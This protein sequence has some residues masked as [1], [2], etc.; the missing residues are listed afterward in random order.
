MWPETVAVTGAGSGIGRAV[1]LA[2]ASRGARVAALDVDE[3]AA[4]AAA[5]A[6]RAAG[7]PDAVAVACDVSSEASVATAF[8]AV[9]D[10]VGDPSAVFANAGIEVN[11]SLHE[12]PAADWERVVAVN[13]VGVFLTCREALRR[14]VAAGRGGSVVCTSSPAA[15]VGHS[16]GGNSAYAASKGGVS[17]FVRSAALDYAPHGIRVNAVVPGATETAMLT[18]GGADLDRIRAAAATQVPLGRLGRPD[19]VAAAVLWLLSDES[20]YVTGSHLVCDG[21]LM[22]KSAN[23]F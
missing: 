11:G 15:F 19:E 12:F 18:A 10:A 16:G 23:D 13:L 3:S 2:A 22:A 14:L 4:T 7:A 20:S 17:A 5:A 8:A 6:A 9:A 1:L 21:G